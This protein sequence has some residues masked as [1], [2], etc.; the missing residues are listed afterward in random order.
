MN[1][2]ITGASRGLGKAIAEIFAANGHSL[3]LCSR[4]EATLL[5]AK[6]ELVSRF[7]AVQI[8]A[9][10]A[11]LSR[12]AEAD[13]F[14]QWVIESGCEVDVLVNNA[15][16]FI[17]GDIPSEPAGA[18]EEMIAVNLYSAYHLT[19]KLLPT[20]IA[21]KQGHVFNMCSIASLQ[22]YPGGGAYSISKFALLG[23]SKNLRLSLRDKGIKVTTV[24]PGA[25]FTDSWRGSGVDP[26]R[27]MEA[28]DIAKMVFAASQLSEQAC[29]EE[30]TL[31]PQLGDL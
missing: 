25:A 30:I 12:P 18:L 6:N 5:E 13:A 4:N 16:S 9:K 2:V 11:D 3:L 19:R 7:P 22:A 29:V 26:K 1:V 27:I 31:R 20:M 24:M 17:P 28:G 10:A 15:G 8:L 23:F 14:G 21:R